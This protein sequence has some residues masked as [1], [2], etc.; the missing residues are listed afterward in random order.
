MAYLITLLCNNN[1]LMLKLY[2]LL[3]LLL[4]GFTIIGYLFSIINPVFLAINTNNATNTITSYIYNTTYSFI[5]NSFF[6]IVIF[7]IIIDLIYS[8]FNPEKIKALLSIIAIL[9]LGYISLT[10]KLVFLP[11]F[12]QFNT[13]TI[14]PLTFS[15]I[16]SNYLIVI[17]IFALIIDAI[18]NMRNVEV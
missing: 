16:T 12:A 7:V 1:D 14:L 8:W 4:L 6:A 2:I 11:I 3:F 13:N 15:F 17:I 5:D 10:F 18:F 9:F